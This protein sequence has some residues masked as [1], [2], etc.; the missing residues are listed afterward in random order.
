MT[1][2]LSVPDLAS[3]SPSAW[4]TQV[5]EKHRVKSVALFSPAAH[6][7]CFSQ[8]PLHPKSTRLCVVWIPAKQAALG[9]RAA[10]KQER[11]YSDHLHRRT[12]YSRY[13]ELVPISNIGWSCSWRGFASTIILGPKACSV[14]ECDVD[15]SPDLIP[16]YG[17]ARQAPETQALGFCGQFVS[18]S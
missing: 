12:Q 10:T 15:E 17:V 13:I 14:S 6:S 5:R 1:H 9:F 2:C 7:V 3:N 16:C 8:F 11:F 4:Y 18:T